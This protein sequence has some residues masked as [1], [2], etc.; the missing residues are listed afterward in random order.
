MSDIRG[1]CCM[2]RR[3]CNATHFTLQQEYCTPGVRSLIGTESS[4]SVSGDEKR[5]KDQHLGELI[6]NEKRRSSR[7]NECNKKNRRTCA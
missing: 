7:S 4:E 6:H 5:Q 2:L 3:G 1:Q